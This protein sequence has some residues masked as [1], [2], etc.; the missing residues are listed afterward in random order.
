MAVRRSAPFD[1]ASLAG[2]PDAE[3]AYHAGRSVEAAAQELV[4]R[5]ERP[6]FNLIERLVHER[7]V[8]E[9][10][11]QDTF[12]KVFRKLQTF[13]A[14]LRFSAWILR[15]AHNTT[16]DHLRR[17]RPATVSLDFKSDEDAS[18]LGERLPDEHALPP[19]EAFALQRTA[20][21]V[22]A[23]L[24]RLRPEYR[25][26]LVLRYQEGLEYE[27]IAQVLGRPLGTI[28]TFVHRARRMLAREL[29]TIL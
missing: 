17:H 16:I 5:Y 29:S 26:V 24:G 13:D 10:L 19:D 3:V 14:R 22:D 25:E 20:I 23:A 7:A 18:T 21:T 27:E 2:A 15:I 6:V 11:T 28:K 9:E 4:R 8:A 12:L 1:P